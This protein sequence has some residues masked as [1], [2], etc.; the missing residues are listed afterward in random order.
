MAYL[1]SRL[2]KPIYM[3]QPNG[4]EQDIKGSL[5]CK[6]EGSLYGLDPASKIWYDALTSLLKDLD[7]REK[8]EIKDLLIPKKYFNMEIKEV[9]DENIGPLN[10][11]RKSTGRFMFILAGAP[12]G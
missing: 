10:N 1:H 11:D 4:F 12:I 7:F 8:L 3:R 6:V 5:V 9:L 2:K